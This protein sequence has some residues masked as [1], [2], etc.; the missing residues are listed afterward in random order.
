MKNSQNTMS[1]P[2]LNVEKTGQN[3]SALRKKA[4]MSVKD[5]QGMLGFTN[6]AAIYKW[7]KGECMPSLDN[8]VVLARILG[9]KVDD[10]LIVDDIQIAKPKRRENNGVES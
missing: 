4:G 6:P 9:V 1:M 5:V 7:M 3:I 10:I 2:V 8:L